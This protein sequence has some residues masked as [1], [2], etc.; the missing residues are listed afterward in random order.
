MSERDDVE[1]E[2]E[3]NQ[4]RVRDE[5]DVGLDENVVEG[6]GNNEGI[7][8]DLGDGLLGDGDDSRDGDDRRRR[9]DTIA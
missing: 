9:D 5:Q 1:R 3:E 7:L 2:I 6:P 4:R 8:D